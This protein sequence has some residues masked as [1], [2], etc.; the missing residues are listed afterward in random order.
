MK[1]SKPAFQ[2]QV[3]S[4]TSGC[5]LGEHDEGAQTEFLLTPKRTKRT[6]PLITPITK[7]S[8]NYKTASKLVAP[9]KRD[10]PDSTK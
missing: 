4:G 1:S 2:L 6:K 7:T 10:H 9:K 8:T 5:T 3:V